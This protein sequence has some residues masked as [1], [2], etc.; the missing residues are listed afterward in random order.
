MWQD[1]SQNDNTHA[2]KEDVGVVILS[3]K[4]WNYKAFPSLTSFNKVSFASPNN[5]L[6]FG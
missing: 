6:V 2:S 3:V 4:R 1:L 5:I